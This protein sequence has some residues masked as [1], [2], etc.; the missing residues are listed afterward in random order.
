[1]SLPDQIAAWLREQLA[2]AGADGFVF[3]LSGGVDSAVTAALAVRAVGTGRVL[4]ALLPCHSQ[5]DDARLAHQVAEAFAIPTVTVDLTAA[6]EALAAALPPSDHPLAAAN[7]KPRL[8]MTAWYYLAQSHNYLV[9]GSGNRTEL[10]VGYFTK[11]GDGG[12][13]LL[14]LGGLTKTRV[15]ELARELGVPRE[16]IERPP[17]AGLW[18]GQTDEGEM[19]IT[20]RELDRVLA[21]IEAGDTSGIEPATLEKVQGMIARSAHKRAMPPVF[22]GDEKEMKMGTEEGTANPGPEAG[23]ERSASGGQPDV[24]QAAQ[25]LIELALAEDIGAGDVTSE[26]VLPADLILHGR[27]VARGAGVIAGLPL[28][29]AVF[30]RVDPGLHFV[31]HVH[32]GATVE[33]GDRVAEVAGPGRG[34]LAAERM[35][36]NFLQHLSGIATLTRAFVDAVAGTRAT[37]LDTRKTHPGYRV[38][39]KYAVRMGG[40]HNHRMSLNDMLL[41]KDNHIEAAGSIADAVERARAAHPSLPVEVEVSTLDQLREALALDVDRIMLDN[42]GLE[43][44]RTAVQWTGNRVPLEASGGV[45]LERVAAIAATG[46]DYISIGALTHSAPA[47]DLSMWVSKPARLESPHLESQ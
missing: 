20:Y 45:S 38:L 30:S 29:A 11:Y 44:M 9:L 23:D 36:L 32:D 27:I 18:P 15:W 47:L 8:R 5:P 28:A 6:Y 31:P 24:V 14:P 35:A 46:V 7:V 3:G 41:V 17:S 10:T 43:E 25:S 22:R 19:G 2:A 37:I 34:M 26:A 42:M 21:A 1:M 40:G 16:V 12:V 4:A 39:E 13:D 33:P